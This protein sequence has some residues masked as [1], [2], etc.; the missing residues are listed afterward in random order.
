MQLLHQACSIAT[1]S[2]QIEQN[3]F[4]EIS[5][6]SGFL[7]GEIPLA[8]RVGTWEWLKLV[9]KQSL[10]QKI[11]IG[12]V[13]SHFEQVLMDVNSVCFSFI[14]SEFFKLYCELVEESELN[15]RTDFLRY[16]NLDTPNHNAA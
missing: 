3:F 2:L 7:L 9:P 13:F 10:H 1:S 5:R 11:S 8:I 15:D 12:T 6:L 16:I 14:T 4:L